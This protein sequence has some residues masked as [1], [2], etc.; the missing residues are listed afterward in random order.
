MEQVISRIAKV[1][2]N[3]AKWTD[4]S[5]P[6]LLAIGDDHFDRVM[7]LVDHILVRS[8]GRWRHLYQSERA[9]VLEVSGVL[10][11]QHLTAQ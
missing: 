10:C 9:Y 2:E 3:S 4:F 1:L 7:R 11:E 8:N 6:H 5:V